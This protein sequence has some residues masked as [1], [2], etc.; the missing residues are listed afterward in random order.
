[1]MNYKEYLSQSLSLIQVE[2]VI[3]EVFD[4]PDDFETLFEMMFDEK[5]KYGWRAAWVCEKIAE[6]VPQ[7]FMPYH[8]QRVQQ[9]ALTATEGSI[10]RLA[11]SM[12]LVLGIPRP[13][14]VELINMSFDRMVSPK[15]PIA[16]Q[17]LSMKVLYEIAREIPEIKLE[18]LAYLN[19]V[20]EEDFSPAFNSVR[21]KIMKLK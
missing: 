1:M 17:A 8:I 5:E 16:V 19:N 2:I 13:I 10:M 11:L 18:L 7:F 12:L 15:I 14:S 9:L 21:K 20:D 3:N 6:R 4:S